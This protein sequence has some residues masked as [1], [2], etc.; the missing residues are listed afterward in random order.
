M[1]LEKY[2]L[3]EM[4]VGH[5]LAPTKSEICELINDISTSVINTSN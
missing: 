4:E 1:P 3:S 2:V 5:F